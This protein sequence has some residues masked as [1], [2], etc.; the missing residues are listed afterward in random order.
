M[1]TPP[2]GLPPEPS[3]PKQAAR[4]TSAWARY[5]T[6]GVQMLGVIG[7]GAYGGWW[8]DGRF[9]PSGTPWFLV[10]GALLGCCGAIATVV[11]A[12]LRG[13]R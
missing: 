3:L 9:N 13:S 10:T 7:L 2:S 12:Y 8:L 1:P 6:M 4:L 11:V 5:S